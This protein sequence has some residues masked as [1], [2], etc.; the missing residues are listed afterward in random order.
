MSKIKFNIGN[1]YIGENSVLIQSMSDIKTSQVEK[2]IELTD[3]LQEI[4]CD[5]MRFSLLDHEDIDAIKEIK[6]NV[7]IPVIADIHYSYSFAIDVVDK[8]VDKIRINPINMKDERYLPKL[9][10]SCKERGVAI[11]IGINEGSFVKEKSEDLFSYTDR[12]LKIFESY[13]FNRIVL[14]FK[15]SSIDKTIDLY[16]EASRRYDYPLHIGLTE[17]GL[18]L[19][20]SIYSAS[21]LIPLLKEGIGDTIRVSLS[22]CRDLEIKA[23]KTILK[24][25]NRRDDIPRLIVCPTCGRT[26]GDIKEI[27]DIIDKKLGLISKDIKVAVM[28]CPING[29]GEAK[30]SDIGIAGTASKDRFMLFKDGISLGIYEKKEAIDRLFDYIDNF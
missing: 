1:K 28:G 22:G 15:S 5:M 14:S 16:R 27:A 17:S 6:Q 25:A 9:I 7:S 21:A 18:P 13:D 2:N 4:G 3:H 10:K 12:M 8:G 19:T 20:G 24:I 11:R 23:C 26:T 30:D 29:I